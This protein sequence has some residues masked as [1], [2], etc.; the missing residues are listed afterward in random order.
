MSDINYIKEKIVKTELDVL[1]YW[2]LQEIWD[3]Q[4]FI[5]GVI[6]CFKKEESKKRMLKILDGNI[7][8]TDEILIQA[9]AIDRNIT[10]EEIKNMYDL[11]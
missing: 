10:P 4:H 9:M 2:R 11:W 8:D 5:L 7:N 6:H 3:N 1:L